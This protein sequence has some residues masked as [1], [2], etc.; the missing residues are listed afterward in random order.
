METL[1]FRRQISHLCFSI[2]IMLFFVFGVLGFDGCSASDEDIAVT[3]HSS[4]NDESAMVQTEKVTCIITEI[5]IPELLVEVTASSTEGLSLGS[6]VR[7][8]TS[9]I[10]AETIEAL[11]IGDTIRFEFSGVIGMSEPPYVSA[12]KLEVDS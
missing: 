5:D 1:K 4:N 9:Q 8:N 11:Q 6:L 7:V 3:D 12:T 10:D 2:L